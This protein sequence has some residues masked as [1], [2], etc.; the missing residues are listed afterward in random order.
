MNYL[1]IIYNACK[2]PIIFGLLIFVAI[3]LFNWGIIQL[4]S[5]FCGPPT[6]LGIL[7]SI[8]TTPAP[9]CS[10]MATIL[11][12]TTGLSS[13]MILTSVSTII[14]TLTSKL[15]NYIKVKSKQ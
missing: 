9:H 7:H 14:F 15:S 4:L 2:N 5:Y 11:S 13:Q 3:G 6:L 10:G 1:P 12:T 8:L